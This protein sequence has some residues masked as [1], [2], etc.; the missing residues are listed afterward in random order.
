MSLLQPGDYDDILGSRD[1]QNG[2]CFPEEFPGEIEKQV[3]RFAVGELLLVFKC[4]IRRC[5][6]REF[7]VEQ[8]KVYFTVIGQALQEL[9]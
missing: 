4:V 9:W 7:S 5:L 6:D 8:S 1:Q 3:H 2:C